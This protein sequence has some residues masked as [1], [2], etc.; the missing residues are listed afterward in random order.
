MKTT[1]TL[2]SVAASVLFTVAFSLTLLQALAVGLASG[3]LGGL[4]IVALD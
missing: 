3:A 1:I 2:L 4:F